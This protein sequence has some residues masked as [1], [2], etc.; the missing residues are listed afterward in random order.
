MSCDRKNIAFDWHFPT[1]DLCEDSQWLFFENESCTSEAC[2]SF[3]NKL[4]CEF[5]TEIFLQRPF[6]VQVIKN[7]FQFKFIY[8]FIYVIL[9]YDYRN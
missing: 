9:N 3:K 2:Y 7:K 4:Q 6:I 1:I 8:T 5:H